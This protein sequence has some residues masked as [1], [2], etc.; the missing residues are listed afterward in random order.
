MPRA[1]AVSRRCPRLPASTSHIQ[2][3]P[4][5]RATGGHPGRPGADLGRDRG[6]RGPVGRSGSG[7]RS[8]RV[9]SP[10]KAIRGGEAGPG[11]L[12]RPAAA[13]FWPLR[14]LMVSSL[15]A[16]APAPAPRLP[17]EN[18]VKRLLL[19]P[20]LLAIAL[21]AA[22]AAAPQKSSR[23]AP[24]RPR[25]PLPPRPPRPPRWIRSRCSRRRWPGLDQDRATCTASA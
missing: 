25:P 18:S 12:I 23:Q 17:K 24:A 22:A 13:R 5:G 19:V 4:E 8:G 20:V 21:G 2:L 14:T 1:S 11:C 6:C 15:P 3:G 9:R 10:A 16:A 7:D